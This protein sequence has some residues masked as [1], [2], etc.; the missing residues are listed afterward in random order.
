ME[1]ASSEVFIWQVL[2]TLSLNQKCS[3]MYSD[4]NGQS[5]LIT[6][7]LRT[8]PLSRLNHF[9]IHPAK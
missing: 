2:I 6:C 9:S 7:H 8:V 5:T 1:W 4:G 3:L